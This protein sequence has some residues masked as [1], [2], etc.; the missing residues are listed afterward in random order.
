MMTGPVPDRVPARR[1]SGCPTTM[2]DADARTKSGVIH[3]ARAASRARVSRRQ[4]VGGGGAVVRVARSWC[5]DCVVGV[6]VPSLLDRVRYCTSAS[7]CV[8]AAAARRSSASR[9]SGSPA[10]DVRASG[11]RSTRATNSSSGLPRLRA[12]AGE[13]VEV[14]PDLCR[15]RPPA[16]TCGSC[17]SRSARRPPRPA[18][19]P[20]PAAASPC[21]SSHASNAAGVHHDRLRAHDRVAEP[22]ELGADRPGSVPEL[23]RRDRRASSRCPARRPASAGTPGTQNEWRTSRARAS[24]ARRSRPSGRRR[25]PR[26]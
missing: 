6:I 5:V 25:S 13:L 7:S 9:R 20:P 18:S 1:A 4:P 15:S 11:R 19:S 14:G 23:R 22:A 17:R 2:P 21:C 8:L 26:R 3:G 10:C 24:R 16:R 12:A